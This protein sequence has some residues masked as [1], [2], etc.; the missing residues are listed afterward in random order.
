MIYSLFLR[1][2][3]SKDFGTFIDHF[4]AFTR[5]GITKE[6]YQALAMS[7]FGTTNYEPDTQLWWQNPMRN[8]SGDTS[9][10]NTTEST[11]GT[12]GTIIYP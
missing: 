8:F 1:Q 9:S 6:M 5:K 10:Y 12:T 4:G 2:W 7:L 3:P 11:T